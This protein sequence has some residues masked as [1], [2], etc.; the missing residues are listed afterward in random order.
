M[1][2]DKQADKGKARYQRG[3]TIGDNS[4]NAMYRE[5][6]IMFAS[7]VI[8]RAAYSRG[9][10]ITNRLGTFPVGKLAVAAGAGA[11]AVDRLLTARKNKQLRAYYGH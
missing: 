11:V 6:A 2:T 10:T 9:V 3:E 4:T 8:S 1:K 5:G 7:G